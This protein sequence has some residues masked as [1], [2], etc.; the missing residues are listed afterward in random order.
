MVRQCFQ[1][2]W[3]RSTN[4]VC[5][6]NI[7]IW[8][9]DRWNLVLQGRPIWYKHLHLDH[10][11]TYIYENHGLEKRSW[12]P[13]NFL[14]I[15][16]FYGP[17]DILSFLEFPWFVAMKFSLFCLRTLELKESPMSFHWNLEWPQ[18]ISRNARMCNRRCLH[19][20]QYDRYALHCVLGSVLNNSNSSTWPTSRI[21][22]L[23][24]HWTGWKLCFVSDLFEE[25]VDLF[26]SRS[27]YPG[28][29]HESSQR[30]SQWD[31][32]IQEVGRP[33]SLRSAL[34]ARDLIRRLQLVAPF[35]HELFRLQRK[36]LG[37]MRGTCFGN[38]LAHHLCNSLQPV[39]P[40]YH[41]PLYFQRWNSCCH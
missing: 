3:E 30:A 26:G 5:N 1:T 41:L 9:F 17:D 20:I 4:F 27:S 25:H 40:F 34:F 39:A 29:E 22:F 18:F 32:A 10:V 8:T 38:R 12:I 15:H 28:H 36:S 24:S 35:Y 33:C 16:L 13:V 37:F 6:E 14:L 31:M 7:L 23:T 11:R 21:I 19:F 2:Y